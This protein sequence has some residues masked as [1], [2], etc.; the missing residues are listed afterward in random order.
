MAKQAGATVSINISGRFVFPSLLPST[1]TLAA[2]LQGFKTY[3]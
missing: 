3:K 2:Q 1:Y